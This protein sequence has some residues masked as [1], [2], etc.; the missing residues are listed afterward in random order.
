MIVSSHAP[1]SLLTTSV[2]I[3]AY[4]RGFWQFKICPDPA[5]NDQRC[6][7]DY[8]LELEDGG[9][10]YYPKRGNARY[11]VTYRLPQGLVCD[12]CVLQWRYTAGNNWGDCKNGTQAL[13]CGNQEQFGACSDIAIGNSRGVSVADKPSYQNEDIPFPLLY[14]LKNGYFEGQ[15]GK[16]EVE[17][18]INTNGLEE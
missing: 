14:Y 11:E 1:G 18:E 7:D 16:D 9:N 15:E 6:F 5:R 12:H 17:D 10:K 13:G 4:H 8:V 2:E 3:T